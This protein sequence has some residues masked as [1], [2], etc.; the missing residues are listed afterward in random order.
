M[1]NVDDLQM[2]Q[3][4]LGIG[5]AKIVDRVLRVGD[6]GTVLQEVLQVDGQNATVRIVGVH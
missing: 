5:R 3:R 6:L 2:G 1:G 4:C